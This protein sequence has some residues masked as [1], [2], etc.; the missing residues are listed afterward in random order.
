M[1]SR[2]PYS[3]ITVIIP[4]FNESGNIEELLKEILRFRGISAIVSDDGSRD[5]TREIARKI[6]R[7]SG[8]I[9]LLDRA[10]ILP[11]GLTASVVDGAKRVKTGFLIVMDGDLQ[12]PPEKIPEITEALKA[13]VDLVICKREKV[14]VEWPLH[15]R[16]IS[17]I[18]TAMAR[19]RLLRGISDPLSG[20][21]GGRTVLFLEALAKR[22]DK[23]EK[24]GYKV[25]FDFLKYAPKSMQ[26]REIP[27]VFGIRKKG[28]SKIGTKQIVSFLRAVFK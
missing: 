6:S 5:G 14:V 25:L 22:E 9:M 23:F 15:R 3:D 10:N 13:G 4:T 11:H 12:H 2:E 19:I 28:A 17:K 8:K 27:Y 21:F 20:F 18:A 7:R 24:R 1:A 16:L 26:I